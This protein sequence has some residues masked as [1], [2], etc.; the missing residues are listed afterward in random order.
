MSHAICVQMFEEASLENAQM[1][2]EQAVEKAG[3]RRHSDYIAR[4]VLLCTPHF[5]PFLQ[6]VAQCCI[7][8]TNCMNVWGGCASG[9][10]GEGQVFSNEATILVAVF[11]KEFEVRQDETFDKNA[12]L[13]LLIVEHEQTLTDHWKLADR[14]PESSR[15]DADAMGLLSYGANYAKMPRVENGRLCDESISSTKLLVENPLVL[16]S[17]GLAFLSPARTVSESNGLFLIRVADEKAAVALK[18]PSEQPRPV[19]LRLQVI[20]EQ[21]ESWIPVMEIHA[22]GTLGL[23]APVMKGQQVRLAQRT[24]KAIDVE[25]KTW[26]PA[27]NTHFN[28]KAPEIGIL[29]AGFERSQMCHADDNDIDSVISH[30]PDTEWIGVFGQAAWLNNADTVVTPPRNNR[31]SLCLFNSPQI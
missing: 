24:P 18:C 26:M 23:A 20:H 12:A 5:A 30:F 4:V 21:G 9:L 1:V 29:F 27:V 13:T 28:N 17:E 2:I 11:G 8:K 16:N 14:E 6:D 19:G 31:L 22:D 25:I 7:S 10:L 15:V 3:L